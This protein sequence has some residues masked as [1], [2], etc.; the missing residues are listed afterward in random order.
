MF[1]A[2]CFFVLPHDQ[3]N[4]L[5]L[6]YLLKKS[7][8]FFSAHFLYEEEICTLKPQ[9]GNNVTYRQNVGRFFVSLECSIYEEGT[10]STF[11]FTSDRQTSIERRAAL[12]GGKRRKLDHRFG[13]YRSEYIIHGYGKICEAA[14]GSHHQRPWEWKQVT[15]M[16][17]PFNV[18]RKSQL[19]RPEN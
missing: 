8:C 14:A 10:S 12:H 19:S 2:F 13:S 11:L 5:S 1:L 15:S 9:M 6:N 7:T 4:P 18:E 16:A 17:L 3:I